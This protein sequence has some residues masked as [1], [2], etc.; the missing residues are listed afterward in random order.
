MPTTDARRVLPL[1]RS[2]ARQA[3]GQAVDASPHRPRRGET[4]YS[5]TKLLPAAA[6]L[7]GDGDPAGLEP[8]PT[9]DDARFV[10]GIGHERP[11]YRYLAAYIHRRATGALPPLNASPGG[12]VALRLWACWHRRALGDDPADD[13]EGL[14]GLGDGCLHPQSFDETPDHWTY[15][16]LAGLHALGALIESAGTDAPGRW[17]Q[18][19][20][21]IAVYH[22]HHTQP[23]YTTYQPW[24]LAVFFS[25]AE[26]RPFAEQQLHDTQTH[27]QIEGGPGALLPALLLADAAASLAASA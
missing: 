8:P 19:A 24:A 21:E 5:L 11:V 17:R 13:V 7:L 26:T 16:E 12:D 20:E 6:A 9:G 14:L 2:L 1:I 23:D 18:R 4:R 10:D 15:R 3:I 25:Y 22:Q 27:L